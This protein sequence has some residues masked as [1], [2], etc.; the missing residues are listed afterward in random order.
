M[1]F[2][3]LQS[4]LVSIL[5]SRVRNGELSE[6]RIARLTGISQPHIHNVLKGTRCFSA[7]IADL[8]LLHMNISLTDLL[9]PHDAGEPARQSPSQTVPELEG[10]L[11]PG[12]A[13]PTRLSAEQH[14]LSFEEVVQIRAPV[15]ARLAR[16]SSMQPAFKE[17]FIALLDESEAK[18]ARL[19]SGTL[20]AVS[21]AG[22]SAVRYA[23]HGMGCLY[24]AT[25][26]NLSRPQEWE[27]ISIVDR[28]PLDIIR[29]RIAWISDPAGISQ[30]L[31]G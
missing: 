16:D 7:E 22:T 11:G 19:D 18:R 8:I 5:R 14:L 13:Y 6:R 25:H 1:Y 4:R 10:R 23:R 29:A 20:Y 31:A 2:E 3:L 30:P 27:S 9:H 26:E 24:L 12:N 28:S 15:V 17:N 21:Q